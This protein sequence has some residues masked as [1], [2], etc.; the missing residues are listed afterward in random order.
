VIDTLTRTSYQEFFTRYVAAVE[1]PDYQ[2]I[3]GYAGYGVERSTQR[4]FDLG[5]A[6]D[7][8]ENALKVARVR[9][10]STAAAAGLQAGDYLLGIDGRMDESTFRTL[11]RRLGE[12]VT[13]RIRRGGT[14]QSLSMTIGSRDDI[15]YR[16]VED[17]A[18]TPEQLKVRDA[19]LRR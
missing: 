7:Q 9:A 3:F 5:M 13:L 14:E 11:S 19:W 8:S 10:G 6:L 1:I 16:I 2:K 12:V 17:A 4:V 18:A 15:T